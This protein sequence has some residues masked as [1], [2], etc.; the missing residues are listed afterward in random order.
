MILDTNALSAF[1]KE[2]RSVL[3]YVDEAEAFCLPVIVLG[4]YRFGLTGSKDRAALTAKLDALVADAT[5]LVIDEFTTREYAAV[6]AEL[7]A[8]GTPIPENDVW[9]AALVRQHNM[10]L[11]TRDGHFDYVPQ[12]ERINW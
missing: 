8:A 9:I 5:V 4:E 11:L 1:L 10:P 6:R 7:K 12:L 3:R 2:D